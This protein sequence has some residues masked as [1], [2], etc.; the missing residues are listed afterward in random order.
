MWFVHGHFR[1]KNLSKV[2]EIF[3]DAIYNISKTATHLYTIVDNEFGYEIS[4][5]FMLMKIGIKENIRSSK[6]VK[7]AL[8]CNRNFYS[9]A[10]QLGLE[11]TFVYID[12]D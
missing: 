10:K 2:K 7:E 9:K 5:S 4:L 3:I 11:S 1:I 6:I 8:A 12:K